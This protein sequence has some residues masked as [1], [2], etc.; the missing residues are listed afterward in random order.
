MPPAAAGFL[1]TGGQQNSAYQSLDTP[2]HTYINDPGEH[3]YT[4][5]EIQNTSESHQ[6]PFNPDPAI[7]VENK[8]M[9][10]VEVMDVGEYIH[11]SGSPSNLP[12]ESVDHLDMTETAQETAIY[13]ALRSQ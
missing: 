12:Y 10:P 7:A 4:T 13:T 11:T 6:E 2:G 1:E 8:G 3:A 9:D 5:L